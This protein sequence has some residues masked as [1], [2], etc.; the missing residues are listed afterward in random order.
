MLFVVATLV[1]AVSAIAV[2]DGGFSKVYRLDVTQDVTMERASTYF[3]YLQYL[4]VAQHPGFPNKRSL[5]QFENPPTICKPF[6]IE[7]ATM[8]LY[9][10]YSHK[11]SYETEETVPFINRTLEL[12]LMKKSWREAQ[13]TSSH[14]LSGVVWSSPGVGLDGTDAEANPVGGTVTISRSTPKGFVRFDVTDAVR[15]WRNGT[16]NYGLVIRAKNERERGRDVRFTSNASPDKSKHAYIL[17]ECNETLPKIS[18]SATLKPALKNTVSTTAVQYGGFSKVYRSDVTQDVTLERASTTLKPALKNSVSTTA[19]QYGG[20]SKV[21]RLDVTQDVTLERASTNFNYL[22][23]LIVA[24]HPGFPNKRSLVQ[25]ENP[26]T[27]CKPFQIESATM[28]L[29]YEYSHKASYE[30]EEAVPFINRTLELHLMKKSWREA[31]ATSSHRLSG[32]VWSS[33]GVGLDGTDAEANPV[34]GTVTISRSTPKG[35]VRFDVTDA[36]RRWR[37]GTPNYGLVIRAKNERER[38]RDVRF[39]SNA[40]PDKSKHAYILLECNETLPKISPSVTLTPALKNTVSTTAVQYGG[41]SKVYRPDVTQDVTLERA[42]TTLKPALKN[43]VSTT[44]VQY[45]WFIKVYR[46][47]VTQDVT[48]ERASTNFNY[49]RYLI[50][51]Q[52]PG[53]PNKRSLVQFENPTTICKPFQSESATMFLYYEYSHKAS[54]ETEE[55]VPFINRTLE[56]HLMKKSW[57]EAQATSSHRLS[58][59][60]WSSPGVGLDG[61]DAE[62]NPVGGT[63]TISR[64]TPKGFVRFDVTDAVRRWRNG[65]PNYGLV[66]RAKNER[67][68]GRDVRFTSNA[69]TDK[70]KHAYILLECNETLPKISPSTTLKP[71]LKN[72]V[73]TTA[74]QYGGFTKV[75]RLDVTQDVTL[76]RASTNFNYLWYLIVA[77]HPGFPNKRSLV[78]FENPTTIC[79]P[80]QSESATMFLYYEYSHKASY[81]TEEAVPFINRTLELHLMKKSWREAQA[82]SSHRLSGVVWSSPGVGLDGTDA[83]ANPVG[84]TVTISRSTPKG[85]VRFDVTDAVR[86]WRNGTPNYGLVIR[87]KN[88][89]ERGRDVRFTSNASPDKSKHAYILLQ[90]KE[91]L[92]KISLSATLKPALKTTFFLIII[93]VYYYY[94]Y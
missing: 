59:V 22:Q 58:G 9:Y 14:R 68:R 86:R 72:T 1:H 49:L 31:Q 83:E 44:A 2:Q 13:A 36:V 5:V 34:G 24:Q 6:Q 53:F 64:S 66:I 20:F 26:T 69:S 43:T 35:F 25:F 52:H 87:A 57:R 84:G 45:G 3:N 70:S 46:L 63:V 19:V 23:Y 16:P 56:L 77:Q 40:S 7:S 62:A 82:T 8:F 4:I 55:A 27:I 71:A 29:Y 92:P 60:V 91:T 32:V 12:H 28:F 61:T 74:V 48:M 94:Y 54:Y 79:K 89:R 33:P 37:N 15:R 88:E 21:Y 76:E 78:Q 80:F 75:Y 85:F 47:D 30:T 81:E 65:T 38:G 50:V 93:I 67:E 39:T 51:A 41:F 18:P 10:E 73:S 42:S 11:A 90:C 17:L